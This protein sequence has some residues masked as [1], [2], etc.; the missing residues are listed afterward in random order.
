MLF[1]RFV[2]KRAGAVVCFSLLRG[3]LATPTR[4]ELGRCEQQ[5]LM[6]FPVHVKH[7]FGGDGFWVWLLAA[8]FFDQMDYR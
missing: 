6:D 8:F 2:G 7:Q 5:R 1:L 3:Q 4:S